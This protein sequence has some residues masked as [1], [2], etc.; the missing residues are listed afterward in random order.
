MDETRTGAA[1]KAVPVVVEITTVL[2]SRK[3]PQYYSTDADA[4]EM[5]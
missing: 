5:Q 4:T 3:R 1:F 2:I